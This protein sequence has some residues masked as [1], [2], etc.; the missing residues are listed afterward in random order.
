M[1]T[2]PSSVTTSSTPNP[3]FNFIAAYGVH[4]SAGRGGYRRGEARSR[5]DH[6]LWF[7]T[8]DPG[9]PLDETVAPDWE[10]LDGTGRFVRT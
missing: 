3:S 7:P 1:P 8:D 9:T 2:G 10:F 5:D 6:R 4:P